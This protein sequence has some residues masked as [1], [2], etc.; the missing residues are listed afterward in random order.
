MNQDLQT[1]N[2]DLALIKSQI[3]KGATDEELALFVNVCKR[4]GLD[5]FARQIYALPRKE[6][7]KATNQY[8]TKMSIQVSIDGFR[9]IA[10][11]SGKY[12]GQQGPF[13]CGEDGVWK[14]VW[15]AQKAPTAAKVGVWKEGAREPTN[16]VALWKEYAQEYGLWGKMPALMLAKVAEAL[17][18]RKA[19]PQELSGLYTTDEMAQ[20]EVVEEHPAPITV[21]CT[22]FT[23]ETCTRDGGPCCFAAKADPTDCSFRGSAKKSL[24]QLKPRSLGASRMVAE[25]SVVQTGILA[26]DAFPTGP[27]AVPVDKSRAKED[28]IDASRKR[29]FARLADAGF[30]T[31]D[32]KA[33]AQALAKK[34]AGK[35]HSADFTLADWERIHE[36]LDARCDW[37]VFCVQEKHLSE[38]E[39]ISWAAQN[40]CPWGEPWAPNQIAALQAIENRGTK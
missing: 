15:T 37:G 2:L 6:K 21:R 24:V 40:G 19:F 28:N 35:D 38:D 23:S 20:A 30:A 12:Q 31:P 4:T 14:D 29:F 1:V 3:C 7:D 25:R 13:W 16:G 18:L 17:A 8:V 36:Q 39:S 27:A 32:Q 33:D 9:L 11:R 26:E 10:E 34:V 22:R 5:P